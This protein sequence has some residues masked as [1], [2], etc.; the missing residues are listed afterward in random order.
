[1]FNAFPFKLLRKIMF[2]LVMRL[3]FFQGSEECKDY[4]SNVLKWSERNE[5]GSWIYLINVA[6]MFE[7]NEVLVWWWLWF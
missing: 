2:L 4:Y 1:M 6:Q 5:Y 3:C 7:R